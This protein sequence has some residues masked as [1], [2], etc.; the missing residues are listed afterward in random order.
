MKRTANPICRSRI[1]SIVR[2]SL[3]IGLACSLLGCGVTVTNTKTT[4]AS[5]AG[6]VPQTFAEALEQLS[7]QKKNIQAAFEK[8]DPESAHDDLHTI[9]RLLESLPNLATKS[10][11]AEADLPAVKE[12]VDALFDAFGKLDETLH[13]GDETPYQDV[14]EKIDTALSALNKLKAK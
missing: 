5:T 12:A 13:G 7:N 1:T 11:I 10:G 9:G 4:G 2:L 6:D 14:A 3:V 8:S